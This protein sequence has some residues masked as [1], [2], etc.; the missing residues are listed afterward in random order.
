MSA[1]TDFKALFEKYQRRVENEVSPDLK[2]SIQKAR[3]AGIDSEFS[4]AL[5]VGARAVRAEIPKLQ[6]RRKALADPTLQLL[7]QA[8]GAHRSPV[9][10]ELFTPSNKHLLGALQDMTISQTLPS[11]SVDNL[12]ALAGMASGRPALLL[13]LRQEIQNRPH[14]SFGST[15]QEQKDGKAKI[16]GSI[17]INVKVDKAAIL[18]SLEEEKEAEELLFQFETSGKADPLRKAEYG[19]RHNALENEIKRIKES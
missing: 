13:A 18:R 11:L 3:R 9:E 16:M 12:E 19:H 8:L 4:D 2:E 7:R 15:P 6:A 14:E 1:L 17:D 10:D 5:N